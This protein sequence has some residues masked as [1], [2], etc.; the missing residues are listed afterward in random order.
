M[1]RYVRLGGERFNLDDVSDLVRIKPAGPM[2][3]FLLSAR[4]SIGFPYAGRVLGVPD[5]FP[6]EVCPYDAAFRENREEL[7]AHPDLPER[8]RRYIEK[9]IPV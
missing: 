9:H 2:L 4:K 1:D 6:K 8:T 7:L 3:R 5:D